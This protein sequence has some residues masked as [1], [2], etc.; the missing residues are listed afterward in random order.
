ML[1]LKSCCCSVV[2]ILIPNNQVFY[3][4]SAHY[5]K[6]NEQSANNT[7]KPIYQVAK[8]QSPIYNFCV[9]LVVNFLR[10]YVSWNLL[11]ELWKQSLV[12]TLLV[13][14]GGRHWYSA[15]GKLIHLPTIFLL[16]DCFFHC[17]SV[18]LTIH[19]I[20]IFLCCFCFTNSPS[21]NSYYACCLLVIVNWWL[22]VACPWID[23]CI[24]FEN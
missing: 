5:L 9:V 17:W 23:H 8:P 1:I 21:S 24:T 22:K 6:K 14:A 4:Q 15:E 18:H 13:A 11:L 2:K 20:L 16:N 3:E 7:E 12:I 10:L 19:S